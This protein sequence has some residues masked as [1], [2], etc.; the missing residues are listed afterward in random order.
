MGKCFLWRRADLEVGFPLI[1]GYLGVVIIPRTKQVLL[2]PNMASERD[3]TRFSPGC[4][5]GSI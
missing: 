3:V 2:I 5:E 4:R 1:I